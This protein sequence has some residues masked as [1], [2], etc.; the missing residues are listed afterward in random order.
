MKNIFRLMFCPLLFCLSTAAPSW[1][2]NNYPDVRII[3]SSEHDLTFSVH[4]SSITSRQREVNTTRYVEYKFENEIAG[5]TPGSPQLP[6][7]QII[8]GIPWGGR[9][10]L[11]VQPGNAGITAAGR[12]VPVPTMRGT[13]LSAYEYYQENPAVYSRNELYPENYYTVDTSCVRFQRILRLYL[14]PVR[15]NPARNTV[16]MVTD[17]IVNVRFAGSG[18]R[19]FRPDVHNESLYRDLVLNYEAARVWRQPGA[20]AG[21]RGKRAALGSGVWYKI[22]VEQEGIYKIPYET[23]RNA[24]L[25]VTDHRQ[26]RLFTGSGR[27]LN[28]ALPSATSLLPQDSLREV[29]LYVSDTAAFGSGDYVLFYGQGLS[30]WEYDTTAHRCQYYKNHYATANYYWLTTD[31]GIAGLR[32][33][34]FAQR[35]APTICSLAMLPARVHYEQDAVFD[36]ENITGKSQRMEWFWKKLMGSQPAELQPFFALPGLLPG[37]P[38]TLKMTM[39]H[40]GATTIILN[41]VALG[42]FTTNE[43]VVTSSLFRSTNNKLEVSDAG[44]YLDWVEVTYPRP[45]RLSGNELWFGLDTTIAIQYKITGFSSGNDLWLFDVTD[46]Y[47]P[48]LCHGVYTDTCRLSLDQQGYRRF[49]VCT[50]AAWKNVTSLGRYTFGGLTNSAGAAYIVITP[51]EFKDALAPLVERRTAAFSTRI[52]AL[53]EIY[54]EFAGGREDITAIRDFLVYAFRTWDPVP[55][56]VLLV[57]DGHYD[58]KHRVA[59]R[60]RDD[61]RNWF[62]PYIDN[63]F[64]CTDDWYVKDINSAPLMSIGRLP[65]HTAAEVQDMVRKILNYEDNQ[66]NALDWKNRLVLVGDDARNPDWPYNADGHIS[67]A[68]DLGMA[69]PREYNLNKI[70]LAEYP[71]N[72]MGQKPEAAELFVREINKGALLVNFVGHGAPD[73]IAHEKVFRYSTDMYK[74]ENNERQPLFW[75]ASCGVGQFDNYNQTTIAEGLINAPSRGS[76]AS[77]AATRETS[78]PSNHALNLNF[79]TRL[80]NDSTN[81][82]IGD[83]LKAA[84][85]TG[86]GELYVLFG[87]PALRLARPHYEVVLDSIMPETLKALAR[88]KISGYIKKD[89][90]WDTFNGEVFIEVFDAA[91]PITRVDYSA[92]GVNS[93]TFNYTLPGGYLFRGNA[94][95][96]NGRFSM[97]FIVPKDISYQRPGGKV[98]A[99]V[100]GPQGDGIGYL[101][102]IFIGGTDTLARYDLQGPTVN[103][104]L[105]DYGES[106]YKFVNNSPRLAAIIEDENGINITGQVGHVML[107]M[108]DGDPELTKDVTNDFVYEKNSWTRGALNYTLYNL[109][110]GRHTVTLRVWDNMNNT[111]EAMVSLNVVSDREFK[112]LNPLNYPNP[113]SYRTNGTTISYVL[114]LAADEASVRIYTVAGRLLRNLPGGM[115]VNYNTVRWDGL[116]EYGNRLANGTYLYVVMAKR[117]YFEGL[118]KKTITSRATGYAVIMR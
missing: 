34:S 99:Y 43:I 73:I 27:E 49:L 75:A 78:S 117:A 23:M 66:T 16:S 70:Y 71:L 9:Y 54:D 48:G 57:G 35:T 37:Q 91:K 102:S 38:A 72:L 41:D 67:E 40:G 17:F 39:D 14:F 64:Y 106:D 45:L 24:G 114:N 93:I 110:P 83:A 108:V 10:D 63:F 105:A 74:I 86:G 20:S 11:T 60:G 53:R 28:P 44:N 18:E 98:T 112:V 118:V 65:V 31:A 30:G 61:T 36:Y 87:D 84:K 22:P 81:Y 13:G 96:R 97:T 115:A 5:G 80:F 59:D 94:E 116:D 58:Y 107:L 82:R 3:G 68:E 4:F 88:Q 47:R 95:V 12:I 46:G 26:L 90:L 79:L 109:P 100:Y 50:A 104:R 6:S 32:I 29:A 33:Q 77:I 42:A 103:L 25:S 51:D 56:Y 92:N 55:S 8:I 21:A 85:I 113:F 101:D 1:A 2:K 89:V 7:R 52:V 15:Y 19:G 69:V 62:P 111:T 76:I